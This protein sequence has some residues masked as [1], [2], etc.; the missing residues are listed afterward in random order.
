[1]DHACQFFKLL[2]A[3]GVEIQR[4]DRHFISFRF[5]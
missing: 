5:R 1:L 3:D 2:D 4:V